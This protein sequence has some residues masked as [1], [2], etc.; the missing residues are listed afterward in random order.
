[1]IRAPSR[2]RP[3]AVLVA[4]GAAILTAL[5]LMV[6]VRHLLR[7]AA[8]A[9]V[10]G[11]AAVAAQPLAMAIFAV[12]LLSALGLIIYIVRELWKATRPRNAAGTGGF[13]AGGAIR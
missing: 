10:P 3:G 9:S 11:E 7:D 1:M 8:L 5:S 6:A 12:T 2:A 4:A 13:D